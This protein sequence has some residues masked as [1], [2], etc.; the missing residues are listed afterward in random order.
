MHTDYMYICTYTG[1]ILD[2]V[3]VDLP[4]VDSVYGSVHNSDN[5]LICHEHICYHY[6]AEFRINL[7]KVN[8]K[9]K[10]SFRFLPLH[11]TKV[12]EYDVAFCIH[13]RSV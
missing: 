11:N 1:C 12:P 9:V 13:F 4:C 10:I 8:S 2:V 5:N 6:S 3:Y 7:A